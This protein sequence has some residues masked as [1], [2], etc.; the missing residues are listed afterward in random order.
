MTKSEEKF[1][2]AKMMRMNNFCFSALCVAKKVECENEPL[3]NLVHHYREV[4]LPHTRTHEQARTHADT[5]TCHL[6]LFPSLTRVYI[7]AHTQL[8][9][10]FISHTQAHSHTRTHT[11]AHEHFLSFFMG[12]KKKR[13]KKRAERKF[14]EAVK[15]QKCEGHSK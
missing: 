7:Q 3:I 10:C 15:K 5:L 12:S 8:H 2:S 6:F 1:V 11:N 14:I 4:F 9:T 13:K